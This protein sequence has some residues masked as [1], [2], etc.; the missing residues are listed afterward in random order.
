MKMCLLFSIADWKPFSRIGF[1]ERKHFF[2]SKMDHGFLWM[3]RASFSS[4]AT[5]FAVVTFQDFIICGHPLTLWAFISRSN[6]IILSFWQNFLVAGSNFLV[7]FRG[8][9]PEPMHCIIEIPECASTHR[10]NCVQFDLEVSQRKFPNL[11]EDWNRLFSTGTGRPVH[12][13][14]FDNKMASL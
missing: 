5:H 10:L 8:N 2:Q 11:Q 4:F 9:D 13:I 7:C 12:Q 3:F 14:L 1:I 6:I